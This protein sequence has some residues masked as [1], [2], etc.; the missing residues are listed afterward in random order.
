MPTASLNNEKS[1]ENQMTTE[2]AISNELASNFVF[3]TDMNFREYYQNENLNEYF[4]I[5]ENELTDK[6]DNNDTD[7]NEYIQNESL[8]LINQIN[9]TNILDPLL[10][11]L[12]L[13][14]F[15]Y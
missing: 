15:N 7:S 2:H 10:K 5:D 1:L 14:N 8:S 12:K 11:R 13:F 6:Q 3:D 4:Y 9:N